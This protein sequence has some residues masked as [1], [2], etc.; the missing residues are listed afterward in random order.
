MSLDYHWHGGWSCLLQVQQFG[1]ECPWIIIGMVVGLVY[2]KLWYGD[3]RFI[4]DFVM[5]PQ[6]FGEECPWIIIGMVVGLVYFKLWYG[7]P[8]FIYDFVIHKQ[9]GLYRTLLETFLIDYLGL[10]T[11]MAAT[12]FAMSTKYSQ[13]TDHVATF[14]VIYGIFLCFGEC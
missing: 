14:A 13:L 2:F 9:V 10:K 8:R 5:Y 12:G 6:Q 4:Y 7:D 3:P 11:T 1:E